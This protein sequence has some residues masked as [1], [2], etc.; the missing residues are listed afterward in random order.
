MTGVARDGKTEIARD[1]LAPT[2][3]RFALCVALARNHAEP[4]LITCMLRAARSDMS[5]PRALTAYAQTQR[6]Q[7][8]NKL[9][10]ILDSPA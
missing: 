1:A 8:R 6:S 4:N 9:N 7:S 5:P 10:E 2:P 3:L